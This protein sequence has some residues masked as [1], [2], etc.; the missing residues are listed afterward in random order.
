MSKKTEIS[1]KTN[2]ASKRSSKVKTAPAETD[3]SNKETAN[4]KKTKG[5]KRNEGKCC[6]CASFANHPGRCKSTGEFKARKGDG[7]KRYRYRY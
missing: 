7:C 1:K 6:S 4:Q 2:V 5:I 3:V